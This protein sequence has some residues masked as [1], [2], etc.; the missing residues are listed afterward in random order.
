MDPNYPP[1]AYPNQPVQ[2]QGMGCFAKGCLTL[3]VLLMIMGVIVGIIGWRF[4]GQVR[5]YI[6]DKPATIQVQPGTNAQYAELQRKMQP[7]AAALQANKEATLS[8]T[9]DEMNM[10]VARDQNFA[11]LKGKAFFAIEGNDLVADMSLPIDESKSQPSYFNARL[12]TS[13]AIENGNIELFPKAIDPLGGKKAPSWIASFVTNRD[14]MR[15]FNEKFN[16][17]FKRNPNAAAMMAK[18]R[19]VRIENGQ[20]TITTSGTPVAGGWQ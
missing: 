9:A 12:I 2:K 4:Y 16:E 17:S 3:I 20:F 10:L 6:S 11:H 5:E 15:G 13:V 1:T 19:S 18:L 7:F 14:F 8:L